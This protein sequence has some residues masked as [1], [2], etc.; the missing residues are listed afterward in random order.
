M[1]ERQRIE[2]IARVRPWFGEEEVVEVAS[3]TTVRLGAREFEFDAAFGSEATQQDIYDKVRPLVRHVLEGGNATVLAYGQTGSGKTHTMVGLMPLAVDELFAEAGADWHATCSYLEV[4]NDVVR[5]LFAE[6]AELTVQADA[7][8]VVRLS[9]STPSGRISEVRVP[10]RTAQD[11]RD[12]LRVGQDERESAATKANLNSSRSHALFEVKVVKK[13]VVG[14]LL[15]VDLAG[16]ENAKRTGDGGSVRRQEAKSINTSLLALGSIITALASKETGHIRWRDSPL[17]RLLRE[18][19]LT[20]KTVLVACVSPAKSARDESLSTLNYAKVA[21]GISTV[22]KTNFCAEP[23]KA[24]V[25]KD[26]ENKIQ[27]VRDDA[28]RDE[29]AFRLVSDALATAAFE[30]ELENERMV[31]ELKADVGRHRARAIEDIARAKALAGSIRLKERLSSDK[32]RRLE[33]SL[34]TVE[35]SVCVAALAS[36]AAQFA[37]RTA[38]E[39][40]ERNDWNNQQRRAEFVAAE[41]DLSLAQDECNRSRAEATRLKAELGAVATVVA[42]KDNALADARRVADALA[43]DRARLAD[44]I[45]AATTLMGA[46]RAEHARALDEIEVA[47]NSEIDSRDSEI[48]SLRDSLDASETK[49][50]DAIAAAHLELAN[51]QQAA[52]DELQ[53]RCAEFD[54][55]HGARLRGLGAELDAAKALAEQQKDEHEAQVA[56]LC[57]DVSA[58]EATAAR[59]AAECDDLRSQIADSTL[60]RSRLQDAHRERDVVQADAKVLLESRDAEISLLRDSVEQLKDEHDAR[61][62]TLCDDVTAAEADAAR[63]AAACDDL[64]AQIGDSTLLRSQLQDSLKELDAVN[65]EATAQASAVEG[66]RRELATCNDK[67]AR[68]AAAQAARLAAAHAAE[69]EAANVTF[70][71]ERAKLRFMYDAQLHKSGREQADTLQQLKDAHAGELAATRRDRDAAQAELAAANSSSGIS[72]AL[73]AALA[74][75]AADKANSDATLAAL[76]TTVTGLETENRAKDAEIAYASRQVEAGALLKRRVTDLE[77]E[78][79][80]GQATLAEAVAAHAREVRSLKNTIANQARKFSGHDVGNDAAVAKR[81]PRAIKST[82]KPVVVDENLRHSLAKPPK[83]PTTNEYRRKLRSSVRNA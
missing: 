8:E 38:T 54:R 12:C 33:V 34:N 82:P 40:A 31:V 15:L 53:T 1:G 71:S 70:K 25:V 77:A 72:S 73:A 5:D 28:L 36:S 55:D 37:A 11:A 23:V 48:A 32:A 27:A 49:R 81:T 14:T 52:A 6:H 64:H 29:V 4:Y 57:E 17:T 42:E 19:L 44:A 79:D 60:L 16:S 75:A 43:H 78:L 67:A 18:P 58:A 61:V 41:H 66:L 10:V 50:N 51:V 46:Q 22:K 47:F 45:D 7:H 65:A 56:A 21:R 2:V 30:L 24:S 9:R 63:F 80:Q 35:A 62:A 76:Q 59:V 83:E 69:L 74:A 3:E 26:L 20:S 39:A 13:R 68:A